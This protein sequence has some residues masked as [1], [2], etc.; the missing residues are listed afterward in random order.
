MAQAG[1]HRAD[2]GVI[3]FTADHAQQ[4]SE[5]VT[6]LARAIGTDCVTG[7]SGAGVLTGAGEIEGD[8]GVAVMAF[9]S[10]QFS[11]RPFLFEPLRGNEAKL[12]ETFGGFL[13][14]AQD[15]NSLMLLF[16][17]TYNGNAQSLLQAIEA[18]AGFHPIAGAGATEN[19]AAGATYQL[20]GDKLASNS[21][22]GMYI[23]GNFETHIDITQ[24]CQPITQPMTITKAEKNLIHEID[25]QPALDVF[26]KLL[27]GPLA[28][29]LR[30]AL[31]VLFVGLPADRR[32]NSVA[33]G[34]Y[35][36]RNIVG[37]DPQKG[38]VAVAD[39]VSEGQA[40]IFALRDG[41]RARDD[42]QEMLER[43]RLHLNGRTPSFGFYFN[44]CARGSSL[45]GIP[46]IDAAYIK[47]ALGDFPLIGMFGGYELAPLGRA[48]HLFAYT[49]VLVLVTE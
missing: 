42:L 41:Q 22:A 27:K 38:I 17:D 14:K 19:G 16:P 33:G 35:L 21:L 12:G 24:G 2:G 47:Q 6:A 32:E 10:D 7:A 11:A 9:A 28:D 25:H 46:G 36:V 13:A 43:Q 30:R 4:S 23:S 39:E 3:Y 44:C 15:E 40:M 48:N 37:L 31:T 20:C 8:H 26:A 49:G 29:D 5:L 1:I 45:Y 34:K 18:R